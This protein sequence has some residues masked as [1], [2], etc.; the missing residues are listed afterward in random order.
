MLLVMALLLLYLALLIC[1]LIQIIIRPHHSRRIRYAVIH[2]IWT[3]PKVVICI[4]LIVVFI[5]S[6]IWHFRETRWIVVIHE[7]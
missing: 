6:H 4:Q 2:Q 3:W 7:L 5:G 1:Q